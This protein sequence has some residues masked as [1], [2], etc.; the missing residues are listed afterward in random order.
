MVCGQASSEIATKEMP[1]QT[2]AI[3][4]EMPHCGITEE[5]D[6]RVD[7]TKLHQRPKMIEN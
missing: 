6:R 2:L 3:M 4:T 7:I 5:V 1:R